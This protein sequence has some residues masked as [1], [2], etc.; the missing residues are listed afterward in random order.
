MNLD[1]MKKK[2]KKEKEKKEKAKPV[3]NIHSSEIRH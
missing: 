3:L 2:I 1:K